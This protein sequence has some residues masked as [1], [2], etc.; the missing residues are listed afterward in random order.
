MKN[1]IKILNISL[2]AAFIFSILLSFVTFEARCEDLR[3]NVF[4]LHIIANSD[5]AEDQAL[6]LKI[7]DA[8]LAESENLF[9][10]AD[11]LEDAIRLTESKLPQIKEVAERVIRDEGFSYSVKIGVDKAFFDTREYDDFVLPAGNYDALKIEIGE[12]AGKNWWCV[13]FPSICIGSAGDLT[14]TARNDSASVAKNPKKYTIR[15]KIVE[16]YETIK[17]K[18]F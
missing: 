15:F 17:R 7:R 12:A 13:L 16:W 10:D 6:K 3:K 2:A 9:S 4:R 8:I 1:K 14:D 5:S 11:S 18:I